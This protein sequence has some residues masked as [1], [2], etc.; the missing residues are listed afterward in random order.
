MTEVIAECMSESVAAVTRA[1]TF[2][3]FKS[4]ANSRTLFIFGAKILGFSK[5]AAESC[6]LPVRGFRDAGDVARAENKENLIRLRQLDPSLA[7]V[8]FGGTLAQA[9]FI[10]IPGSSGGK[11][12]HGNIVGS[13]GSEKQHIEIRR[14][15]DSPS[16]YSR[17][18]GDGVGRLLRGNRDFLSRGFGET[19]LGARSRL[20]YKVPRLRAG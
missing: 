1:Q 20:K 4:V 19:R 16:E 3:N 6:A 8:E 9:E 2:R 10:R 12:E 13:G 15:R 11:I 18:V 7:G 5:G 17:G 14:V